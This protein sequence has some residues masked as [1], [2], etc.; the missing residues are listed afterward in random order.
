[1]QQI[2]KY[3]VDWREGKQY[4]GPKSK[5]DIPDLDG[6][7]AL[8]TEQWVA[9]LDRYDCL[10]ATPEQ[11]KTLEAFRQFLTFKYEL[12]RDDGGIAD[13]SIIKNNFEGFQEN[14]KRDSGFDNPV[15]FK[16]YYV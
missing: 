12:K 13:L 7:L 9:A 5:L 2:Q 3:V 1:M 10:S 14:W 4:M 8:S 11:T 15:H 16:V 6:F